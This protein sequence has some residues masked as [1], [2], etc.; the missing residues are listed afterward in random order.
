MLGE[1]VDDAAAG[2]QTGHDRQHCEH[3]AG[4]LGEMFRYVARVMKPFHN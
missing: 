3:T 1:E 4:C 2:R